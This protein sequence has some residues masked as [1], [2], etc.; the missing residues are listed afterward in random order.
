MGK[1]LNVASHSV[2]GGPKKSLN[3][4]TKKLEAAKADGENQMLFNNIMNV[5][6]TV[7]NGKNI[8]KRW[9]AKKRYTMLHQQKHAQASIKTLLYR[10]E[11]KLRQS[12]D[13]QLPSI[14]EQKA[15]EIPPA[16]YEKTE[17]SFDPST[18]ELD[19]EVLQQ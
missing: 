14:I 2:K 18:D 16:D 17:R 11:N 8:S 15:A 4:T 6:S 13:G 19:L 10:R 5:K 7:P 3:Q 9:T 1:R 12:K